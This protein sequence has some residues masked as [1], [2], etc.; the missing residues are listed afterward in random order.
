[1]ESY[2]KEREE[3]IKE[4]LTAVSINSGSK[5]EAE[6]YKKYLEKHVEL[7]AKKENPKLIEVVK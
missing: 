6:N 2:L 1:L 4:V 5:P 7:L 3:E